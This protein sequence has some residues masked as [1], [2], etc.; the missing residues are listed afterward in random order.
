MEDP[1]KQLRRDYASAAEAMQIF[2]VQTQ[3]LYA[4]VSRGWIRSV[5]QKGSWRTPPLRHGRREP[6]T[7]SLRAPG[8]RAGRAFPFVPL[9]RPR[10]KFI[11][12]HQSLPT[13]ESTKT[14]NA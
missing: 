5:A 8:H 7:A 9:L 4:H 14:K 11:E 12:P 3:T 2:N 1:D 6:G 10:A 13:E